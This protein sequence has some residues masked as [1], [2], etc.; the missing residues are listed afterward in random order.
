MGDV[1]AGARHR[2][3]LEAAA[4]RQR[5]GPVETVRPAIGPEL[6]L[7]IVLRQRVADQERHRVIGE[8]IAALEAQEDVPLVAVA[9]RAGIVN[10]PRVGTFDRENFQNFTQ[11]AVL[12][13]VI[14]GRLGCGIFFP[15]VHQRHVLTAGAMTGLAANAHFCPR[16]FIFRLGNVVALDDVR[17]MTVETVGVPDL[18]EVVG[19]LRDRGDLLP[20]DP[21]PGRD[22]P[23]HRQHVDAPFRQHR[24]IPLVALRPERVV[25]VES[26][27]GSSAER[28][29]DVRLAV[30]R[31]ERVCA[32]VIRKLGTLAEVTD[33]GGFSDRLGHLDV[34]R[35]LPLRV[36]D[37]MAS[38]ASA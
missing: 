23:E 1:T 17:A 7:Q 22:M 36:F 11:L 25:N 6:A 13:A 19:A 4:Q 16:R 35:I 2:A 20:V 34:E 12:R 27:G 21:A 5:L 15:R 32:A 14:V 18:P 3:G 28:D 8:P 10:P 9:I 26:L 29:R 24:Q 33:H 37:V 38:L 31:S 30:L